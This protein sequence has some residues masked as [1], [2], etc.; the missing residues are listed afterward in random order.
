M[1]PSV[2]FLDFNT[3][4]LADI[5]AICLH[6]YTTGFESRLIRLSYTARLNAYALRARDFQDFPQSPMQLLAPQ[7]PTTC[8]WW[9][10]RPPPH[11]GI[12]FITLP[13]CKLYRLPKYF[14]WEPCPCRPIPSAN[15][16]GVEYSRKKDC[17]F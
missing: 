2:L 12:H 11:A 14:Q 17:T 15:F 16:A 10:G 13:M 7:Q 3:T 8:Q 6:R 9:N 1:T 5:L 4:G